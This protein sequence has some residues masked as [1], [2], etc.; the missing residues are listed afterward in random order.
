[1]LGWSRAIVPWSSP[2]RMPT[3]T[4]P[5]SYH[6]YLDIHNMCIYIQDGMTALDLQERVHRGYGLYGHS[7]VVGVLIGAIM[8]AGQD[9]NARI[10]RVI[11]VYLCTRAWVLLQVYVG[12]EG[13]ISL[14]LI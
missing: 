9:L 2:H 5:T 11:S 7:E 1:M 12:S 14:D 6:P 4:S 13:G 8:A 10:G 3:H